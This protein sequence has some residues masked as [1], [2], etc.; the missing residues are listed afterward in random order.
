MLYWFWFIKLV[1]LFNWNFVIYNF[2]VLAGRELPPRFRR[3]QGQ[4]TGDSSSSSQEHLPPWEQDDQPRRSPQPGS[5]GQSKSSTPPT[6]SQPLALPRSSAMNGGGHI[7]LRP[8]SNFNT[9][10]RPNTPSM[11]PKSAQGPPTFNSM[12][13]NRDVISTEPRPA[14]IMQKQPQIQIKQVATQ[15]KSKP[16]KKAPTKEELKHNTVSW[17]IKTTVPTNWSIIEVSNFL[18]IL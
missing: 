2:S 14:P 5:G 15:E 12:M 18:W 9:L 16:V 7:N 4:Q 6:Y 11:L 8:A 17:I 1:I 13:P 10:F 3:M